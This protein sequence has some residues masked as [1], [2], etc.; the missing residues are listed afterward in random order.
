MPGTTVPH[1]SN[2]LIYG[3]GLTIGGQNAGRMLIAGNIE[4]G[5]RAIPILD[6]ASNNAVAYFEFHE[7]PKITGQSKTKTPLFQYP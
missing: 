4:V 3:F 6:P 7:Q 1:A 5:K 2:K